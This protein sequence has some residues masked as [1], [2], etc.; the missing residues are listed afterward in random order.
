M[1]QARPQLRKASGAPRATVSG[2]G[3]RALSSRSRPSVD[4][5]LAVLPTHLAVVQD[6]TVTRPQRSPHT[7]D[8]FALRNATIMLDFAEILL[9]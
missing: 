3:S 6:G 9:A 4:G 2:T 1:H 5:S 7:D 8:A